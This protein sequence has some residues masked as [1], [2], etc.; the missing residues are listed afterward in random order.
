MRVR[1]R[2]LPPV[3]AEADPKTVEKA[4]ASM[5]AFDAMPA[6]WRTFCASYGRTTRG[7]SLAD[8]LAFC[9]G[10][11]AEAAERLAMA[12]PLTPPPPLRPPKQ[13]IATYD[14]K[15]RRQRRKP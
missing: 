2:A 15:R 5:A 9:G 13:P 14:L 11:I 4:I 10:D 3:V 12:L 6:E 8:L 1:R 7:E